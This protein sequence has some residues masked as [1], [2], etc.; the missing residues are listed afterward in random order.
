[1]YKFSKR[2]IYFVA[3]SFI[4]YVFYRYWGYYSLP[5]N[6]RPRHELYNWLKP[7]GEFS[8]GLGIIG[9]AM[10][11][12]LLF[13]SVRKRTRIFKRWGPVS[14]WL[15]IHI[16]FGTIGPLL[17]IL[18]STFKLN[19]IISVSFWS[20][21]LVALSGF[22]G[23]YLYTQIPRNLRGRE[24]TLEEI[25]RRSHRLSEELQKRYGIDS[26]ELAQIEKAVSV[27]NPNISLPVLVFGILIAD[28][29]RMFTFKALKKELMRR[30]RISRVDAANF[31]Q[32][33]NEKALLDRRKLIWE[34]VHTLFHY[35]HVFHKPF[36]VIMYLIMFIHVGITTWLGYTWIF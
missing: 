3:L 19:G 23:R 35:W 24:L 26:Q 4:A 1:M 8:H 32:Q 33:V 12:L 29:R 17:V 28:I 5:Y 30:H 22:V 25:A 21:V 31:L 20:M 11:L 18:H 2:L 36:A 6:L 7:G 10:M 27:S 13:Y 14:R 34:K 16:F 9:S 15:D